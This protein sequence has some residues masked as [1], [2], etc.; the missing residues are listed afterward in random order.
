MH[1]KCKSGNF[2]DCLNSCDNCNEQTLDSLNRNNNC[3]SV[4]GAP[5]KYGYSSTK[6]ICECSLV[7]K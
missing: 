2:V 7:Q 3:M 4:C 1:Q 5:L 6:S